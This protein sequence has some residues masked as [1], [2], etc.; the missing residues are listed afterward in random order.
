MNPKETYNI[1]DSLPEVVQ[2]NKTNVLDLY[3]IIGNFTGTFVMG[4][5]Y[6]NRDIVVYNGSQYY[7][8]AEGFTAS[9]TPDVD[10]KNWVLYLLKGEKGDIGATGAKG[11]TGTS[12][13]AVE[14]KGTTQG[15]GFTITHCEAVLSNGEK[16]TFD[17]QAKDGAVGPQG[18]V[19]PVGPQGPK[20][21]KGSATLDVDSL[22][23]LLS[24]G[25]G[26]TTDLDSTGKKVEVKLDDNIKLGST[27]IPIEGRITSLEIVTFPTGDRPYFITLDKDGIQYRY[28]NNSLTR[29]NNL[30]IESVDMSSGGEIVKTY[31][32]EGNVKTIFDQ[33]I[34]GSGDITLYR[35]TVK[36]SVTGGTITFSEISSN[37]LVIDSL[38][39]LKTVFGNSF[40]FNAHGDV[41]GHLVDSVTADGFCS[42]A[43]DL[44]VG[45]WSRLTGT[46][47]SEQVGGLTFTDTVTTL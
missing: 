34:Y 2:K 15:E 12:I 1:C 25:N 35:H 38:D 22:N 29:I 36:A 26:I 21:E 27:Q 33:S 8:I 23:G 43:L 10:D 17:V 11:D 19:G 41:R 32:N 9:K 24:G 18:P 31:L 6:N 42:W 46:W 37:G 28:G 14:N 13:V 44:E 3:D 20:G 16:E 30:K 5:Y 39:K 47:A 4:K 45:T 7:C 40:E